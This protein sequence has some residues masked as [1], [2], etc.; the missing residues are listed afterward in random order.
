MTSLTAQIKE[1]AYASGFDKVGITAARQPGKSAYLTE[2]LNRSYHGTM[3]WMDTHRSKRISIQEF[4]PGARSVICVACNYN[5]PDIHSSD[6]ARGKI[7]RYAWG[8]DYHKIIKKKLKRLLSEI[9][10]YD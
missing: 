6:P 9:K 5:A 4:V 3:N 8:E 10:K 7:S 1:L 2:W